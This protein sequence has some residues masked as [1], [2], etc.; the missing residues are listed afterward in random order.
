MA[1]KKREKPCKPRGVPSKGIHGGGGK[2]RLTEVQKVLLGGGA[3]R[4]FKPVGHLRNGPV[5]D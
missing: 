3:A 2:T 4:R 5:A 1:K